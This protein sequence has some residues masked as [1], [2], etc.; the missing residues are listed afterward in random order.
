MQDRE[1][2]AVLGEPDQA[3][4]VFAMNSRREFMRTGRAL[5]R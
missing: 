5:R 4:A 1:F 3:T 2:M